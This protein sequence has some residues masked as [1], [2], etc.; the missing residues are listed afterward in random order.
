MKTLRNTFVTGMVTVLLLTGV[1]PG[2]WGQPAPTLPF[3]GELRG[4]VRVRGYVVCANCTLREVRKSQPGLTR[5]YQLTH[6]E[7]RAVLK[8]EWVNERAWWDSIVGL[9]HRIQARGAESVLQKLWAEENLF[10][11]LEVIGLLRTTRVLDIH[12]VILGSSEG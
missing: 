4:V 8:V 11:D 3:G 5:L 9:S 2:A 6:G 12:D 1:A 10:E 7:K